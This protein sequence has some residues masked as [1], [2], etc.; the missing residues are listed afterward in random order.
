MRC[1][2]GVTLSDRGA[3]PLVGT[4]RLGEG[5]CAVAGLAG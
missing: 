3:W 1:P 5:E 2:V 4:A